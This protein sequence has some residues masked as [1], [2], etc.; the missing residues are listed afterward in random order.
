MRVGQGDD[1]LR[2]LHNWLRHEDDLRGQLQLTRAALHRDQMGG[3]LDALVVAVGS[4]G[5]LAVLAGALSTWISQRHSDVKVTVTSEDGR[6][7]E[8]D[9][10]RVD[11]QI[12]L[13]ELR[14]LLDPPEPPQ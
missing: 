3:L 8:F 6:K 9:G 14:R 12:V 4:G 1:D 2:A 7:V 10:H 13:R 11:P 5:M